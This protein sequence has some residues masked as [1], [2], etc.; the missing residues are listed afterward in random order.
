MTQKD[1]RREGPNTTLSFTQTKTQ[2]T[3]IVSI[4]AVPMTI[5]ER[6]KMRQRDLRPSATSTRRDKSVQH[7]RLRAHDVM[8]HFLSGADKQLI[9][10]DSFSKFTA[11]A[12]VYVL[13]QMKRA[14]HG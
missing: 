2:T 14:P 11:G 7:A 10:N 1:T 4:Q 5:L 13:S 9:S 8:M 3:A 6:A 12:I